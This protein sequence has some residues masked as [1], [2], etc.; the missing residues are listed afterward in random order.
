M[1]REDILLQERAGVVEFVGGVLPIL[2]AGAIPR[3]KSRTPK[4]SIFV[5]KETEMR[6]TSPSGAS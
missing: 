1:E 6:P 2:S 3:Q 5:A 4:L